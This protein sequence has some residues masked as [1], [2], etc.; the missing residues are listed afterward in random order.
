MVNTIALT[1]VPVA[2]VTVLGYVAGRRK[3][4]GVPDRTTLNR[5]VL[6]W[7]L[8]PLL[9]A[10]IATTPRAD[11]LDYRI[12]LIFLVGLLGPY[13]VVLLVARYVMRC[14]WP[15]A[16]IKASLVAFPDMV[17]MGIPILSQ[18]FGPGSLYPIL[19]ANLIPSLSI[20]PL[21]TVLLELGSDQVKDEARR[22][23]SHVFVETMARA[24][25]EPRV[26]V[27]FAA[28][29]L[30]LLNVPIP[31]VVTTSLDLIGKATTGIS[32]FVVGLI[33]AEEHVQMTGAVT[34]DVVLKNLVHPAI[35]LLTV[36]AFGVSGALAREAILLAAIPSAVI[37][38]MFA[39]QYGILTAESSTA[40]LAT[41]IAAFATI[42]VVVI[43][44][45]QL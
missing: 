20:M 10:G 27:P 4:F 16:A 31:N 45:A 18:L 11:L 32:L 14:D 42:P 22:P 15:T 29:A 36:L 41:R 37:T 33:V 28:A 40:I 1:L 12:P 3:F 34:A 21:T 35:M 8:P 23:G 13:L 24:L 38:T 2:F 25:G 19:V 7:L 30:V 5:L 6:T 43:V 26:W 44:T 39:E 9:F 17:F